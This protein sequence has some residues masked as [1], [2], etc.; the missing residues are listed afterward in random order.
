M[1]EGEAIP[2]R[3]EDFRAPQDCEWS[4]AG[5]RSS[6][7]GDNGLLEDVDRAEMAYADGFAMENKKR[8]KSLSRMVAFQYGPS[9]GRRVCWILP[10]CPSHMPRQIKPPLQS[11]WAVSHYWEAMGRSV[12]MD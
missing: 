6:L 8:L 3:V 12:G 7:R 11:A 4:E 2:G 1:L 9:C 5:S 10:R